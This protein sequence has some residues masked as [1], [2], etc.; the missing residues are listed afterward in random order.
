MTALSVSDTSS[1]L[2]PVDVF[3][4]VCYFALLAI[5]GLVVARRTAKE[6][7]QSGE[8]YFLA[9]RSVRWWAVGASLFASNIGAEHFVGLSG[10]AAFSGLAVGFYEWGAV[11]CLLVLGYYFLPVYFNARI[12]TMP[13]WLEERYNGFCGTVLVGISLAL[14]VLTKIAA[15][16]F[17]GELI[18][19]EISNLNSW[20]AVLLLIAGTAAYTVTGGLAAVIYTEALQTLILFAGGFVLLGSA[21]HKIGGFQNFGGFKYEDQPHYYE[22]FRPASDPE[23]PW[24]GF[25]TGYYS[26]SLWYWC[27]D[28]VIVQRVIAAKTV[29]HGRAGCVAAGFL[30]LLP[31]F[32]MVIPGIIA[33]QLM[34]EEGLIGKDSPRSEYDRAF[35]WLV[36]NCM[37]TNSRGILIAAMIAA[38]MSSLASVFNSCATIFTFDVYKK[39][40]TQVPT[41]KEL[42]WVGRITVVVVALMS[43]AWLPIIPLLGN[44]LFLWVQKPPSY[45][46]PPILCLFFWGS[47]L[48]WV[49]SKGAMCTLAIGITFGMSRLILEMA[50]TL[51]D[52][53]KP[54]DIP[55]LSSFV[56]MNFLH[57]SFLNFILS[58]SI[59]LLVSSAYPERASKK[60]ISHLLWKLDLY[61]TLRKTE[62]CK[63]VDPR[64]TEG[65]EMEMVKLNTK[66]DS[67]DPRFANEEDDQG[68]VT[69]S[70]DV[71]VDKEE[72]PELSQE[73]QRALKRSNLASLAIHSAS[74]ILVVALA[75]VLVAFK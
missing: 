8:G 27:T 35:T 37:P 25:L 58:S 2:G 18:L 56:E 50:S 42:V 59:L 34:T 17:A 67:L 73:V 4:L 9:E 10:L 69:L 38:L 24:T 6:G 57:F 68:M 65:D 43:C 64:I 70:L 28:Q 15:T 22:I 13:K 1:G 16:L 55:L 30:K 72:K 23:F 52:R 47:M 66:E 45:M 36:L 26:T 71:D 39:Y 51:S 29:Q 61:T 12:E 44:Q 20:V 49:N 3:T 19:T 53:L 11:V 46:A 31:G 54:D 33:R 62:A 48:K 63:E 7:P 14:Y 60:D 40:K 32:I 21:L 5:I 41:E 75:C 74:I